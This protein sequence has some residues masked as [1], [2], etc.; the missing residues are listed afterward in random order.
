L[1]AVLSV[2]AG[3]PIGLLLRAEAERQDLPTRLVRVLV[4]N[5]RSSDGGVHKSLA[6]VATA[7][8]VAAIV[9]CPERASAARL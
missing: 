4:R 1:W 9:T 2:L 5:V 6:E 3:G 7:K 8:D